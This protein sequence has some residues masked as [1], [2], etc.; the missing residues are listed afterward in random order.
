MQPGAR[1]RDGE[2][3]R[4]FRARRRAVGRS[5][6][7]ACML[8]HPLAPVRRNLAGATQVHVPAIVSTLVAANSQQTVKRYFKLPQACSR[9]FAAATAGA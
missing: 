6:E 8:Q 2:R 3:S 4:L 9:H 7:A 5:D 1:R